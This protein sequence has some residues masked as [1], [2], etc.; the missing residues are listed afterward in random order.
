MMDV[1]TPLKI[2]AFT[3][4]LNMVLDPVLMFGCPA[5]GIPA[6]GVGGV[7]MATSIS[8]L[9]SFFVYLF[10]LFRKR[11]VSAASLLRP[12]T[13]ASLRHLLAGAGAVQMRA[14]TLNLAFI[15]VTRTTLALDATGTSAAAHTVTT[16]LW[17]LGGIFLMSLSSITSAL[18]PQWL[19]RKGNGGLAAAKRIADRL[20]MWGF[21][22]GIVLGFAQ[23][24]SLPLLNLFTEIVEVR[25]AAVVPSIIGAFLQVINGVVFCGE[26]IMVGHQAFGRPPSRTPPASRQPQHPSLLPD[27]PSASAVTNP[28]LDGESLRLGL[29]FSGPHSRADGLTTTA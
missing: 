25:Q 17:Y 26:G 7:A 18:V 14:L 4:G 6:L 19:N 3:Q 2:S 22:L 23:L 11:L 12:P 27:L 8:E 9:A 15:F 28:S 16:Q 24:L 20:L 21:A 10:L 13:A 5:L 29:L 1:V